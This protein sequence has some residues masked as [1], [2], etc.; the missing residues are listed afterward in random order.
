MDDY[1]RRLSYNP[2]NCTDEVELCKICGDE[3]QEDEDGFEYC[4]NCDCCKWCEEFNNDC[5]CEDY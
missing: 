4:K 2:I 5:Y 1:V 3:I